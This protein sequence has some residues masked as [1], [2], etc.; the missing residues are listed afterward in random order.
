[1]WETWLSAWAFVAFSF[2]A[3]KQGRVRFL[4]LPMYV[5][6]ICKFCS[7]DLWAQV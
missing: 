2:G 1:V 7:V 5:L 6:R 4:G 3:H